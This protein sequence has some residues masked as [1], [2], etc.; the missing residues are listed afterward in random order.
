[1]DDKRVGFEEEQ[2]QSCRTHTRLKQ[3]YFN[4]HLWVEHGFFYEPSPWMDLPPEEKN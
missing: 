2:M 1:M 3:V 4:E